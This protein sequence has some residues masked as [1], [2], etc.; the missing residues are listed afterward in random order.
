MVKIVVAAAKGRPAVHR[1]WL[2]AT[3]QVVSRDIGR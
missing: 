3:L 2:G 1:P